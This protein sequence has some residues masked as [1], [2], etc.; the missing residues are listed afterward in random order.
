MRADDLDW[1]IEVAHHVGIGFTSIQN[2]KEYLAK[3]VDTVVK[4]FGA[5]LPSQQ[6]IYIF[7][8][9]NSDG[10]RVG[11]SGIDIDVGYRDI[12]Y[13]Y[14][15]SSVT[16]S[17]KRLNISMEHHIIRIVNN[18]QYASELVSFWVHPDFRDKHVGKS[19][20][21][22]RLLFVAEFPEWFGAEIIAEIRGLCDENGISPFWEAVG[23]KFFDMDFKRADYLSS[24]SKQFIGDLVSREP[25][26]IDLLPQSAQEVIG[27]P[28][29]ESEPAMHIL[30]QQGFK[31]AKHIDVFDGGP[32]ISAHLDQIKTITSSKLV[33]LS[34]V[35]NK[36][37]ADTQALLFNA[38]LD[39]AITVGAFDLDANGEIILSKDTAEIL[40][41]SAGDPL[42]YYKL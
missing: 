32:L 18:Y 39:A 8:R 1:L 3:R 21:L 40:K 37:P 29:P 36:L 13:N 17:N 6:R 41:V 16:Q 24:L 15:I 9:E 7:V 30:M 22:S 2:N 5:Q 34:K 26:Y 28:H 33:K 20:S 31:F 27:I 12:F 19:L 42:R 38:R 23:R 10:Q 4:S 35:V 11:I 14:Q 25:I